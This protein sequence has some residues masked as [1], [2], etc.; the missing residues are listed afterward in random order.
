MIQ[1]K[2]QHPYTPR[3]VGSAGFGPAAPLWEG[4]GRVVNAA[5]VVSLISDELA[6]IIDDAISSDQTL[7][8]R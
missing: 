4:A 3:D 8:G 7:S 6:I 5:E 2:L 1:R